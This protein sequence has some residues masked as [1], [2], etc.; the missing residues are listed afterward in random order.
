MK[1]RLYATVIGC[2]AIAVLAAFLGPFLAKWMSSAAPYREQQERL[3][4]FYQQSIFGPLGRP[5]QPMPAALARHVP[6][7]L[8]LGL[9]WMQVALF[10]RRAALCVR[11]KRIEAPSSLNVAWNVILLIG[12][13]PWLL[14]AAAVL[15]PRII[16]PLLTKELLFGQAIA[17]AFLVPYLWI[18]AANTLGIAFFLLEAFSVWKDGAFPRPNSTLQATP[19]SGRA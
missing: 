1:S 9:F 13:V 8:L 5:A 12:A 19:A 2:V 4:W 7:F 14:A 11:A 10:L 18:V 15:L 17:Q 16:A 3:Y 6:A